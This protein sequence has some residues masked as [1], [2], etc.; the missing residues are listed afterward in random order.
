MGLTLK[1]KHTVSF[2]IIIIA[3]S[4]LFAGPPVRIKL[5]T[6]AP[7]NSCWEAALREMGQELEKELD[8]ELRFSLYSGG[9]AGDES[10]I[11][12]KMRLGQFQAATITTVGLSIIDSAITALSHIPLFYQSY[13]ELDYIRDELTPWLKERFYERGF[14]ILNWGDAGWVRFFTEQPM[15]H[16]DQLKPQ[17]LFFW[18]NEAGDPRLWLEFGFQPVPLAAT[19]VLM[20]L[21]TGLIDAFDTTPLIALGNQWFA[22][23]PNMSTMLWAPL[24]GATI[25]KREVWDRF[26][27]AQQETIAEITRRFG[28]QLQDEAR[29]T[30]QQAI[31]TMVQ[32]GLTVHEVP[33]AD[34]EVWRSMVTGIYP[35]IRGWMVPVEAFDRV[36]AS[37]ARFRQDN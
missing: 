6:M 3:A 15:T 12:R 35:R 29:T 23:A 32:Y 20:G 14:V 2:I 19:D 22:L 37:R 9:V 16:P 34:L 7:R 27:A 13:E 17:K 5:A 24:I 18:S 8:G 28:Q 26:D 33:S 30:D 1:L 25:I 11:V 36:A 4:N 21:Q 10:N 31:D